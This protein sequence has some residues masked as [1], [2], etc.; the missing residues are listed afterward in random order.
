MQNPYQYTMYQQ[1]KGK[2]LSTR[3][4]A[5]KC[6][7]N[8]SH[9]TINSNRSH[10]F[11]YIYAH[12]HAHKLREAFQFLSVIP[13]IYSNN[14]IWDSISNGIFF[15]FFFSFFAFI[16]FKYF[17]SNHRYLA[18]FPSFTIRKRSTYL[19]KFLFCAMCKWNFHSVN[20]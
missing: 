16:M 9:L 8:V 10:V 5:A 2:N 1:I 13:M 18:N 4:L 11:I 14:P 6:L 20:P 15:S 7:H 12:I 3:L 17:H 19:I